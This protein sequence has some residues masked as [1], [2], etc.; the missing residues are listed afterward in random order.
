M[1]GLA[2]HHVGIAC[3]DIAAAALYVAKAY[4]ISSDSGTVYDP[5]Q[6]AYVRLFNEGS[7]GAIEL[8][9]GRAVETLLKHR[10]TYYH[11]CYTTPDMSA[12]LDAARKCGAVALGP[13]KPAVLFGGRPVAFVYTPLGIVEFLAES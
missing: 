2:F 11:I 9:S 10:A 3:K 4:Q 8:V 7:P 13:P 1:F 12:T 6:D 5:L